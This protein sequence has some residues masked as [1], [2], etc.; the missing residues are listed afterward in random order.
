MADLPR[1]ARSW[2]RHL[3]IVL[4]LLFTAGLQLYVSW[5]TVFDQPLRADAGE[6][7]SYAYNLHRSGVYSL[8]PWW[9][10]AP[11]GGVQPDSIRPP[12]YPLFLLAL[13]A[14]RA[15]FDYLLRIELAQGVLA[16]LSVLLVYVLGRRFLPRGMAFAAA[17]VTAASPHLS[18][19]ATNVLSET[20]FTFM[21]LL[22]TYASVLALEARPRKRWPWLWAGAAWGLASLVRP[23]VE[24]LPPLLAAAA[25]LL[26]A[27]KSLRSGAAIGLLGFA[28]AL[29]PWAWRN[30]HADVQ[31]PSSSLMVKALAHGSYPG[32]MYQDRPETFGFPYRFDPEAERIARDLPSVLHHIAG[33]FRE[34]PVRYA[35]WYLAKPG[36]F[37]A[38]GNIQGWDIFVV[39]VT[40]SPWAQDRLLYGLRLAEQLLHWPLMLLGL[41]GAVMLLRSRV[42]QERQAAAMV[43]IVVAYAVGF[44]IVVAPFPRYGVPF[45]PLLYLLAMLPLLALVSRA[46]RLAQSN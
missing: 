20:L 34:E 27:C 15:Q 35:L 17:A 9:L 33:R 23:T 36:Y 42:P 11:P 28:L 6:Y 43:A 22:A 26:P 31:S 21:L 7:F 39:P 4:L 24:L 5:E 14:P 2:P 1:A 30:T 19:L 13:G 41:G 25:F 18:T 29:A 45:R 46:P 32:F 37:L 38:W 12:G 3:P 16:V 8:H 44:H 40:R 10:E